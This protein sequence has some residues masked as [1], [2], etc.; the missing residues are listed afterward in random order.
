MIWRPYKQIGG[1]AAMEG[2]LL[3]R[4]HHQTLR[5][6]IYRH[7]QFNKKLEV[8]PHLKLNDVC[9]PKVKYIM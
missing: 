6:Q 1:L 9:N 4:W 8:N 2:E 5:L 3:I 7:T